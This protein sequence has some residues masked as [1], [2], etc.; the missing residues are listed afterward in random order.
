MECVSDWQ[1]VIDALALVLG[2]IGMA[3]V[4]GVFWLIIA[5]LR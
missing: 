5:T 4:I 2:V 3:G 1:P